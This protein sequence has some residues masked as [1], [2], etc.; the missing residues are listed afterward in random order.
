[1]TS[2]SEYFLKSKDTVES[3]FLKEANYPFRVIHIYMGV[4]VYWHL[5]VPC[6]FVCLCDIKKNTCVRPQ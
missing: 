3:K 2:T 6:V 4:S 5:S 1:M